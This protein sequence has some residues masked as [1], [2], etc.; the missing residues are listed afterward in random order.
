MRF[1]ALLKDGDL[2]AVP[3]EVRGGTNAR[4]AGSDNCY[5]S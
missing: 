5:V 1:I 4:D 3:E 2:E